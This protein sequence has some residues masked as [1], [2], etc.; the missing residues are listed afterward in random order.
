M[1]RIIIMIFL[2]FSM[3]VYAINIINIEHSANLYNRLALDYNL[4]SEVKFIKIIEWF[5][6]EVQTIEYISKF[7]KDTN[8]IS[9]MYYF[10]D[11]KKIICTIEFQ[12]Y[13]KDLSFKNILMK[14]CVNGSIKNYQSIDAINMMLTLLNNNNNFEYYGK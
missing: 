7:D 8:I 11:C 1:K 5:S 2:L 9:A 12:L 13:G 6:K 14:M 3:N 4:N 10:K